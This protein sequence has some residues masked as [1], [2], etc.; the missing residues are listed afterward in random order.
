MKLNITRTVP[1]ISFLVMMLLNAVPPAHA[2]P[3]S[4]AGVAGSYGFTITGTLGAVPL[5]AAGKIL[6]KADGSLLGTEARSVGGEFAD[7][8]LTGT[9]TVNSDCT[10]TLTGE[11]FES[12]KLVRTSVFSIIFDDNM[13]EVRAVQKSLTLPNGTTLPA[14]ITVE[15]KR[16]FPNDEQN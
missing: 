7:E 11:I 8:T 12:G 1:V 4:T 2:Q 14:V 16:M 3:C 13:K 6:L 15:A 10:G 5:A 9:Y